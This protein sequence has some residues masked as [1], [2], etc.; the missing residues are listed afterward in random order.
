MKLMPA[1]RAAATM[2]PA[3]ALS[4]RSPN[5]IVPRQTGETFRPLR[6]RFRYSMEAPENRGRTPISLRELGVRPRFCHGLDE[7]HPRAHAGEEKRDLG[8]FVGRVVV[9][10]VG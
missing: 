1:S 4:V 8:R 2:R 9:L 3:S 6:P 10:V 7:A 5:I